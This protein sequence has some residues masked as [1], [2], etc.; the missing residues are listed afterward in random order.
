MQTGVDF[1]AS[2]PGSPSPSVSGHPYSSVSERAA[3][4]SLV[5]LLGSGVKVLPLLIFHG[6]GFIKPS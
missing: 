2:V 3:A 5:G 4:R 6:L 1:C